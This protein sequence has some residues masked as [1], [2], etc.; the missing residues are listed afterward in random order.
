MAFR[1]M[2]A[3]ALAS[4]TADQ[5]TMRTQYDG[6]RVDPLTP[7]MGA[8]VVGVDMAVVDEQQAA[9]IHQA[10]MDW[11]VLFFRDQDITVEQHIAFGRKFGE[12]EIHPFLP[13]NGHAE[14]VVLDSQGSA[15]YQ[16]N[17]W[18]TD[19]TFREKPP[20]GSILRGSVIPAVG[21]DTCWIDMERRYDA[22]DDELKSLLEG[23]TAT[24][25]LSKTFGRS[26]DPEEQERKL[27]EFP[28][29]H[30]PCVRT[31]PVTGRKSLFLNRQF[32]ECIDDI[33]P[34]ESA[35]VL[36]KVTG[37]AAYAQLEHQVRFRWQ[38]NSF[39]MWDNRCT[40]HYA[41]DDFWPGTREVRRVTMVGERPY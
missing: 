10:W 8:E 33:D 7:G 34:D 37:A 9:E 28:N 31:H 13:N 18:H 29:Q 26:M 32:V 2:R 16:A 5:L 20:M 17:A 41:T 12:L 4:A 24:H 35:R 22:L 14:I 30:H 11:K 15:P 3:L 40:Q 36:A 1:P 23:R 25:T 19:V 6:F 39:A 38:P 27:A 21:G